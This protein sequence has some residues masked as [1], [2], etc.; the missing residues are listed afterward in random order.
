[1]FFRKKKKEATNIINQDFRQ[2][3]AYPYYPILIST[4]YSI[5]WQTENIDLRYPLSVYPL[6]NHYSSPEFDNTAED[7]SDLFS[8]NPNYERLLILKQPSSPLLDSQ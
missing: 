7:R 1:M 4:F 6:N 3:E 2:I 8:Y 5:P